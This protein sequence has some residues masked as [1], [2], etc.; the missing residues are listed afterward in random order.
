M[1]VAMA[2][3]P[4]GTVTF[5]FTDIEG[6]TKL[7]RKYPDVWPMIQARHH[8]LL[9]TAITAHQ[10]YIFRTIGDEFNVAFETALEALTAAIAAQY[11][12]QTEDWG[13]IGSIHVRIGLHTGLAKPHANEYE[14]YL[15][16]SYTKRLMSI[17]Y[18]G[19]I[20]LSESAE[21]LLRDS[22]PK[23]ITLRDMGEHRLKDFERSEHVFQVVAQ[24]LP[25]EFPQLKS[26]DISPNNLPVQ[27]TSFIGRS[28]E[29]DE[30]K[31]MLSKERLLTLTGSS[32]SGKTR[33]ALQ[34]AVEMIEYF[35][36][37]VFFVPLA[38]ITEP[39]LVASTIAQSLGAIESSA[40][41]IMDSLKDYLQN[42]SLLLLLDNFEQVIS[43]AP[44]VAELLVACI[45]LK[46]LITSREGLHVSGEIEYPVLPLELPNLKQL[47]PL[48]SLSH[49]AAVELFIQRAKA[50]K[51]GFEITN[52]TAP[53]V[54]EICYR[55]DG[56]PLAI[57]LA[58]ARI[59]LLPPP[60]MLTRL[61]HRLEFLTG[62]GRDAPVRQ[63]TLRNAIAWSYDLL[64]E[65]EQ[66]LFQ[67]LSV[68]IGGF[69]LD[70]VEAV[71]EENPS[72]GLVLDRLE[73]LLD[74]SLLQEVEGTNSELRFVMLETLREYGSEQLEA[75]GEQSTIRQRHANFF[76]SIAEQTKARL[77]SAGQV[78]WIDRM[79][80]EHDNLRAALEWSKT[81]DGAAETCLR[82]AD[83][84][85]LFWEVRGYYTEGR[86]RLA[87]ILLTDPAQGRTA[88]R[89]I[90]C[91][92][93]R[94]CLSSKRLFGD[95]ILRR[96]ESGNLP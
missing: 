33:L 19:Q 63:Q 81:A 54:A 36:D 92:G 23:G 26:L 68:F 6:S 10:G 32:G 59:K 87:A 96:R 12:L 11:A 1:V 7:A 51:P 35:N 78:E 21:T 40:R 18:G 41:T 56:L 90:T 80:Q 88:S 34:V 45:E 20:L 15:T 67:R 71:A 29:K 58:A 65:N 64:D 13:V 85:G 82:L 94:A 50:V 53:A 44:L 84:L 16:L 55:L 73:S 25:A 72:P 9:E 89:Q 70:A 39:G 4:T 30:V 14:G 95:Q 2:K 49:Y 47:P 3:L 46:I 74:K 42:K 38:P 24:D 57:E 27:L 5:L 22:L 79:E 62:G 77:G 48:E 52:T 86:E 37:G 83:A 93:V 66:K 91:Q 76:L 69:T 8:T 17:A 75:N 60:A 61:E 28:R 31:Q 43:A